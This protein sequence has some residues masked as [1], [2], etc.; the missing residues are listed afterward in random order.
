[1]IKNLTILLLALSLGISV[2][3]KY[4][5]EKGFRDGYA[6]Q[7]SDQ[8]DEAVRYITTNITFCESSNRHEETWGDGGAAYGVAQF[9]KPTFNW[10]KNLAGHPEYNWK[11]KDDQLKLLDWAIRNG[12]GKHW[13][14][15][16]KRA[17]TTFKTEILKGVTF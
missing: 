7:I 14:T 10:M 9:H 6:A 1:M 16:Y 17:V 11:S 12:Y 4:S 3:Y 8:H 2:T 15:C 5:Y 13:G